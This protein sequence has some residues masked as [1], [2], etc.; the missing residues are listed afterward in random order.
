MRTYINS[1]AHFRRAAV[2]AGVDAWLQNHP[3]MVPFQDWLTRLS[4]RGRSAANPFVV[5]R[6]DY[7]KFLDVM[8]GCSRIALARRAR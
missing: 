2:D 4:T 3:L 1:I 8:D 7:Q 6:G 5:G